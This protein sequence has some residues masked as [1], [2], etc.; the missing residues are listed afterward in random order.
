[1]IAARN[2]GV[3]HENGYL[4]ELLCDLHR[5]RT[6]GIAVGDIQRE[7]LRLATDHSGG[8]GRR[9]TIDVERGNGRALAGITEG[10]GAADAGACAGHDR[11]VV[12]EES[13]HGASFPAIIIDTRPAIT[14]N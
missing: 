3:I 9:L 8:F 13:G 7:G 10:D 12:Q 11:N 4:A 5:D 14:M 6:A 2:S 1:R